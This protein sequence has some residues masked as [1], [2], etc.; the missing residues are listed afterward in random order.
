MDAGPRD[1]GERVL[2]AAR[3]QGLPPS[4]IVFT[5]PHADHIGGH[6]PLIEAFRGTRILEAGFAFG[7]QVYRSLLRSLVAQRRSLEVARRGHRFAVGPRVQVEVLAPEE[8]LVTRSRSDANAN[9]VVLKV[10]CGR[11]AMLLAGDAERETE[12]R[13][14]AGGNLAAQILKVAHHGSRY[15]STAEFLAAVRPSIAVISCGRRNRYGHPARSTLDGLARI[16]AVVHRTD[17]EGDVIVRTDG[18]RVEATAAA[19]TPQ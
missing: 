5:H 11:V 12:R 10:V 2:A 1:A 8:P 14:V 18:E 17:L 15:A 13:L 3:L 6:R 4:I 16:G 9:S 7:S 19:P